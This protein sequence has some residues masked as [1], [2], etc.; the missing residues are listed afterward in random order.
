[1]FHSRLSKLLKQTGGATADEYEE[2]YELVDD[3]DADTDNSDTDD[4]ASSS[5][6]DTANMD[7]NSDDDD[8][9]TGDDVLAGD[10][11]ND[12]DGGD[13]NDDDGPMIH[14]DLHRFKE[15]LRNNKDGIIYCKRKT[16]LPRTNNP[17]ASFENTQRFVRLMRYEDALQVML[18]FMLQEEDIKR[19]QEE[20]GLQLQNARFEKTFVSYFE[21]YLTCNADENV[22]H[23]DNTALRGFEASTISCTYNYKL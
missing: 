1:M 10:D 13:E 23:N 7:D 19:L 15:F 22:D 2:G 4:E 5:V 12:D 20:C 9:G 21:R 14:V 8:D 17:F 18:G 16:R 3:T 6:S 11:R